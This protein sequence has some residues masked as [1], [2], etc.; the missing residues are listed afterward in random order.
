MRQRPRAGGW[1]AARF[2]QPAHVR[3]DRVG[4]AFN[5]ACGQIEIGN[6]AIAR[7][8]FMQAGTAQADGKLSAEA[9]IA[10]EQVGTAVC[11]MAG[12]ADRCQ[13][14]VHDADAIGHAAVRARLK[15]ASRR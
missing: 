7:T 4:R 10:V 3:S 11:Y 14:R 1:A 9:R 2:R 12:F 5:I 15:W 8:G 6:A 13:Q